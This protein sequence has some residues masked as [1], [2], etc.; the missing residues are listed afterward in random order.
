MIVLVEFNIA[1]CLLALVPGQFIV[2]TVLM[3]KIELFN[4]LY[5]EMLILF[6]HSFRLS[7]L[8]DGEG[9]GDFG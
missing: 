6:S 5:I 2:F 3:A 1:I 8:T 4:D 9:C 7:L